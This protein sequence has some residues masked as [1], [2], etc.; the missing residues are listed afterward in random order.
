M[1]KWHSC[2]NLKILK[3]N[4]I[5]IFYCKWWL[6]QGCLI[7]WCYWF[8][9]NWKSRGTGFRS[10]WIQLLKKCHLDQGSLLPTLSY[11]V[12]TLFAGFTRQL[13]RQFGVFLIGRVF[14]IPHIQS[15]RNGLLS[16][17]HNK[18]KKF[19]FSRE[20]QHVSCPGL[21][22][23]IVLVLMSNPIQMIWG[24]R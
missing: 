22:V 9:G 13:Q 3:W 21:L 18:R 4:I 1:S 10:G 15:K 8:S 6:K 23:M 11:I 19:H 2:I 17:N 24:H 14:F 20:P 16:Q 5:F 12:L 7:R